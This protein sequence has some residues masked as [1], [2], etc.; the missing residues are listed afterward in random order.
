VR[1]VRCC[2]TH[3]SIVSDRAIWLDGLV[4]PVG[5]RIRFDRRIELLRI[6]SAGVTLVEVF[7]TVFM[8]RCTIGTTTYRAHVRQKHG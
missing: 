7:S 8:I 2:A 3:L 1:R 4:K 5:E 6:S